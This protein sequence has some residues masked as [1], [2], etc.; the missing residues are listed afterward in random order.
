MAE[1]PVLKENIDGSRK[2]ISTKLRISERKKVKM[3]NSIQPIEKQPTMSHNGIKFRRRMHYVRPPEAE[4]VEP[5]GSITWIMLM[6]ITWLLLTSSGRPPEKNLMCKS[7]NMIA[8]IKNKMFYGLISC[9][10]FIAHLL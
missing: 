1:K 6:M 2:K 10:F 8:A 9:I 7:G 5:V 3:K 4:L